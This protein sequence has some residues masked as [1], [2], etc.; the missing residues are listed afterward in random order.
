MVFL[1]GK[2]YAF[3]DG[4]ACTVFDNL[5]H[6][7]K[8]PVTIGVFVQPGN[9]ER[10]DRNGRPASHRSDE[11]DTCTP[12]N[13][14][15]LEKDILAEVGRTY[16]LTTDPNMRAIC[17]MSSGG[18]GA[19]TAAWHRPDLFRRVLSH[20]GSYCDFRSADKYPT[21]DGKVH[22][23]E[24]DPATWKTAHDYAP[25]IRKIRPVKPLRVFLQDGER[26]LDNQLGNWP[27]ANRQM[28]KALT[29]SGYKHRFVMGEGF[30]SGKHGIAIL[31]ES[32]IWLWAN[33]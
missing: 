18:S 24:A 28:D 9:Y 13:A 8:M 16:K 23:D 26:D 31:P 20:I 5:I 19:F 12:R 33:D 14:E 30:H 32:L 3:G 6:A 11:Y 22:P 10:K 15:F 29:F 7:K 25:L 1:D 27:L 17:G 4:N 21:F 2:S